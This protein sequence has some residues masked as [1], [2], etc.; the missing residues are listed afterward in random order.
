MWKHLENLYE[1]TWKIKKSKVANILVEVKRFYAK[2]WRTTRSDF[3]K[4]HFTGVQTQKNGINKDLHDI[5]VTF[6]LSLRS[7]WMMIKIW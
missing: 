6:M 2:I 5:D 3:Q 7:E 4:V 1:G